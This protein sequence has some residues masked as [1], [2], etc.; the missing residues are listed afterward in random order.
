MYSLKDRSYKTILKIVPIGLH[1]KDMTKDEK[2][3]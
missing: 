3:I 1:K 2:K